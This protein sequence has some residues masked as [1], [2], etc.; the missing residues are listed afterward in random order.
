[1][2]S[3]GCGGVNENLEC[4]RE[5]GNIHDIYAVAVLRLEV[6]K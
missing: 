4:Q 3:G 2:K 1:M 6:S 5:N